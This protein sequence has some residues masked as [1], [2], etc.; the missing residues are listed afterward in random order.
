MSAWAPFHWVSI[1]RLSCASVVVPQAAQ[2]HLRSGRA[3]YP[4]RPHRRGRGRRRECNEVEVIALNWQIDANR[5]YRFLVAR[6]PWLTLDL[7][8]RAAGLSCS[9]A[10][11]DPSRSDFAGA[12]ASP[13][14]A[15]TPRRKQHPI[16]GV[17][18]DRGNGITRLTLGAERRAFDT[19]SWCKK[20]QSEC[21]TGDN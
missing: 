14:P 1:A 12:R 2:C 15:Q 4:C 3:C 21:A 10:A 8:R 18:L 17:V 13:A 6:R 9:R 5:G 11:S 19:D 7:S 16:S 20:A